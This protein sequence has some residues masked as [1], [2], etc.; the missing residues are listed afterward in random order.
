MF[1]ET[2]MNTL[3]KM[4]AMSPKATERQQL[5]CLVRNEISDLLSSV[6]EIRPKEAD[7]L[8]GKLSFLL[9]YRDNMMDNMIADYGFKSRVERFWEQCEKDPSQCRFQVLQP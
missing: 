1:Y 3:D 9:A 5:C 6:K 2:D 4:I 7:D 8:Q